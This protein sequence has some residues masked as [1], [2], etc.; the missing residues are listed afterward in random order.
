MKWILAL[1]ILS[2]AC[3]GGSAAVDSAADPGDTEAESAND[4]EGTAGAEAP[5]LSTT[6]A[7]GRN[8]SI[9]V[10]SGY[11]LVITGA[12]ADMMRDEVLTPG[13]V[14]LMAQASDV[15]GASASSIV[16]SPTAADVSSDAVDEGLC[17]QLAEL[18]ARQHE[19][20]VEQSGMVELPWGATCQWVLRL[21]GEET[22]KR[23]GTVF[24]AHA[25]D[26]IVTC[27]HDERDES[28]SAACNEVLSGWSFAN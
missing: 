11:R 24:A 9:P 4:S 20:R 25:E 16:V 28:A 17:G 21:E 2:A 26:W 12:I 22:R 27:N 18:V 19:A 13:G 23:L 14:I 7:T 3:G 15:A 1:L 10:P 8:F 6:R 5:G